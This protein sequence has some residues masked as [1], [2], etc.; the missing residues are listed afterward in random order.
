MSELNLK[1]GEYLDVGRLLLGAFF[2]D[3]AQ[4]SSQI[5]SQS[6][7]A[8]IELAQQRLQ[9]SRYGFPTRRKSGLGHSERAVWVL[10]G[11]AVLY[12]ANWQLQLR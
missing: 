6:H 5:P 11:G 1:E 10:G 3:G 4:G 8:F 7:V 9:G 12:T 2:N